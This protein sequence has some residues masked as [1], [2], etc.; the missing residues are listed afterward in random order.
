[1]SLEQHLLAVAPE[2]VGASTSLT[3]RTGSSA[4]PS[5]TEAGLSALAAAS[6]LGVAGA[7]HSSV[8]ESCERVRWSVD[9]SW[10]GHCQGGESDESEDVE[11]HIEVWVRRL[12]LMFAVDDSGW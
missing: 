10:C 12:E 1:M 3:A 4:R 6:T 7:M 5:S 9:I 2:A 11:T 8:L